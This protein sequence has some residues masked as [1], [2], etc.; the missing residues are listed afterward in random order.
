[1][2]TENETVEPEEENVEDDGYGYHNCDTSLGVQYSSNNA[3]CHYLLL[4]VAKDPILYLLNGANI[5]QK[6]GFPTRVICLTRTSR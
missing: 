2:Q 5:A 4:R 3:K 6:V 1:M